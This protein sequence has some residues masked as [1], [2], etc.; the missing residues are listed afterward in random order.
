MERKLKK[1]ILL[2]LI[3]LLIFSLTACK[4]G[5]HNKEAVKAKIKDYLYQKYGE[6]F[7]V[8]RIGTRS[9]RSGSLYI[10]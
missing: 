2:L 4:M 7:V 1:L 6:E 9:D 5:S 8:D 3:P 10:P